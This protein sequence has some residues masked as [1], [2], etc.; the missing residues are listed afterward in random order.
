MTVPFTDAQSKRISKAYKTRLSY[1]YLVEK[2]KL[3]RPP[4]TDDPNKGKNKSIK[5]LI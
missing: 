4:K 2:V 1:P 3:G 5:F